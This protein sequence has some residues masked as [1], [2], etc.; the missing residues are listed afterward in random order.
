MR[1]ASIFVI[2]SLLQL[3]GRLGSQMLPKCLP[4]VSHMAPGCLPDA[5]GM[6]P[7]CL[8]LYST[9]FYSIL[10]YSTLFYST[11]LYSP[12]LYSIYYIILSREF[13]LGSHAG[14][15]S[16]PPASYNCWWCH[17]PQSY[18]KLPWL[19]G[20]PHGAPPV[21]IGTCSIL[22]PFPKLP[23]IPIAP[24]IFLKIPQDSLV[25]KHHSVWGGRRNPFKVAFSLLAVFL[26]CHSTATSLGY[27]TALPMVPCS[28][29][30]Q[31]DMSLVAERFFHFASFPGSL[32]T[33]DSSGSFGVFF[34]AALILVQGRQLCISVS[35]GT[36][37][38]LPE[39]TCG[40]QSLP[41]RPGT[42]HKIEAMSVMS[43]SRSWHLAIPHLGQYRS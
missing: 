20:Y 7:G 34:M 17:Q 11:L 33:A 15:I 43:A 2:L 21:L 42:S 8:P 3:H 23:G 26:G 25:A 14:V 4:D 37:V 9:L 13:C 10:F 36:H 6:P 28:A 19:T 35:L 16:Y 1:R 22:S 12:L 39:G 32:F 18:P 31:W 30:V 27:S 41:T 5:S 40:S 38:Y 29:I 24:H